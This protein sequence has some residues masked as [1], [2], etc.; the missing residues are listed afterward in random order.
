MSASAKARAACEGSLKELDNIRWDAIWEHVAAVD[1]YLAKMSA[2]YVRYVET[3]LK[4][5]INWLSVE[6]PDAETV[7]IDSPYFRS[8]AAD[9]EAWRR[10]QGLGYAPPPVRETQRNGARE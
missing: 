5:A 2:K 10:Q 6:E 3:D 4:R 1:P 8:L 9:A 7:N